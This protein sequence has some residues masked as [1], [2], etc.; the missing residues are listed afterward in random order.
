M[1]ADPPPLKTFLERVWQKDVEPLLRGRL[2]QQRRVSARVSTKI[3]AT[4]G[5]FMDRVLRLR[6]RPFTRFFSVLGG[7]LGA[8]LPDAWDWEWLRHGASDEDRTA[9]HEAIERRGRDLERREAM[10]ILG[11]P[12]DASWPDVKAAWRRLSLEHHPDHART[13]SQRAEAHV[14]FITYRAAY[15]RLRDLME[16]A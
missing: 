4:G 12:A 5:Y 15:E 3:A 14:R 7:R 8:M 11:L 6:G 1:D 16:T 2:S 10:D 13:P 9:T